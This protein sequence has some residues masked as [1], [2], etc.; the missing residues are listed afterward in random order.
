MIVEPAT[1]DDVAALAELL[2]ELDAYYGDPT[3]R[4]LEQRHDDI[5]RWLF[6]DL[7]AARVL[8]AR[9]GDELVGMASYSFLWPAAGTSGSMY[10]KEIYVRARHSRARPCP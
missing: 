8:V 10:V 5:R 2:A 6:C 4:A 3:T 9:N 7:P 1:A